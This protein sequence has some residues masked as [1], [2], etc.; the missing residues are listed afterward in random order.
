MSLQPVLSRI[1][2]Y[3]IK[4]LDGIEL[5][6]AVISEGGCLLHDREF[7]ITD[8][9][10]NF[11]IGKTNPLVHKLRSSV[12]FEKSI[13]SFHHQDESE[14]VHF[15]YEDDKKELQSYLSKYFNVAVFLQRNSKGRFMDI[16]DIAGITI[17]SGSS[18]KTI[19]EWY[20][21]MDLEETRKRFRSTLEIEG[22]EAFWEDHLFSRKG[23]G[24]E[25]K[26]G[27]VTIYGMSP[28]ARCVVPT[29]NPETGEALHAFPKIFSK[30]RASSL[31]EWSMLEE[32]GHHYFLTVNC[33]IPESEIGKW[34]ETGNEI[35]I[36]GEKNFIE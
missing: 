18:I 36:I 8:E 23:R 13:I 22:V 34:I 19:S 6:R 17:L 1:T 35:K 29:R 16:P 15:H 24:I 4:S 27:D 33:Y 21:N 2:I 3:P 9:N 31:P 12:D 28:R 32:Y 30:H 11:I 20:S 25:F 7:A 14:W 10:G 26:V 5:K